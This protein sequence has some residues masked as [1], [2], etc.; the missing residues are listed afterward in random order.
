LAGA[1]DERTTGTS[2]EK[3]AIIVWYSPS[4]F[5]TTGSARDPW[6]GARQ[7]ICDNVFH[8]TVLHWRIPMRT[9]ALTSNLPKERPCRVTEAPPDSGRLAFGDHDMTGES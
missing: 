4:T 6:P 5:A 9:A 7:L 8:E 1:S 3:K 2:Y